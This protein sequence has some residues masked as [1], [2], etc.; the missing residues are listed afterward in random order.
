MEKC[1]DAP[2]ATDKASSGAMEG[3]RS[4]EAAINLSFRS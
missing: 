2:G 4:S 1:I 3:A